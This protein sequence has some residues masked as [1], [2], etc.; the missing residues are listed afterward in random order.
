[1]TTRQKA[2]KCRQTEQSG[3]TARKDYIMPSATE[4][5]VCESQ[6][7]GWSHPAVQRLRYALET[8][9]GG[10]N[11]LQHEVDEVLVYG[12]W[13]TSFMPFP[14]T[15]ESPEGTRLSAALGR[16]KKRY[17][18]L[19]IVQGFLFK[20]WNPH[21]AVD[22]GVPFDEGFR[23]SLTYTNVE[24]GRWPVNWPLGS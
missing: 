21:D 24:A 16:T 23:A 14:F 1:L 19:T 2:V 11:L 20:F 4:T 5:K 8:K 3:F 22:D 12:C 17:P 18:H 6:V 7:R 10:D 15:V 9:S 13:A